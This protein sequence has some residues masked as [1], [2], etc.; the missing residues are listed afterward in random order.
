MRQFPYPSAGLVVRARDRERQKEGARESK[1]DRGRR[2]TY[3]GH[4]MPSLHPKLLR[5][6]PAAVDRRPKEQLQFD[7][8]VSARKSVGLV[9]V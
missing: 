3:R 2:A 7:A 5:L 6:R 1:G 4:C 8:G 9:S